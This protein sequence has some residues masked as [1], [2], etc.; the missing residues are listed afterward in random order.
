MTPRGLGLIVNTVSVQTVA[1]VT[2]TVTTPTVGVSVMT[3]IQVC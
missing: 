2:G 3:T 1:P